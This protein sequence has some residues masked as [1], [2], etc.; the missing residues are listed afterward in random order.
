V[1]PTG[2][3]LTHP[4]GTSDI[5]NADAT[6][7]EYYNTQDSSPYGKNVQFRMSS[8]GNYTLTVAQNNGALPGVFAGKELWCLT[9]TGLGGAGS[10]VT[11][12]A[13]CRD[14]NLDEMPAV[15]ALVYA[16]AGLWADYSTAGNT[17]TLL[18]RVPGGVT[19]NIHKVV[20]KL[21]TEADHSGMTFRLRGPKDY[22]NA[23]SANTADYYD[24]L[25]NADPGNG[26]ATTLA[27]MD[28]WNPGYRTITVK[29]ENT[30]GY[31]TITIA[32]QVYSGNMYFQENEYWQ[33]TLGG[34]PAAKTFSF[35]LLAVDA[36]GN[37]AS[38][39]LIQA[40]YP[41]VAAISRPSN[42]PSE[43]PY[44]IAKGRSFGLEDT[45]IDL[46]SSYGSL[47][48]S[49]TLDGVNLGG[50]PTD[51]S[52]NDLDQTHTLLLKM[53]ET[54]DPQSAP[55]N[56]VST[57]VDCTND[58]RDSVKFRLIPQENL[59]IPRFALL[60]ANYLPPVIDGVVSD[61][62]GGVPDVSWSGATRLEYQD[63]TTS[64]AA[65]QAL[66]CLDASSNPALY[67]SFETRKDPTYD[68]GDFILLG[69]RG[70]GAVTS[71]DMS[72]TP[73]QGDA[74]ILVYPVSSSAGP[75]T[76]DPRRVEYWAYQGSPAKWTRVSE[77][78]SGLT[79]FETKVRIFDF[80]GAK[81]WDVEV[82]IPM[83]DLD[84]ADAVVW[85]DLKDNFLF[86]YDVGMVDT[87]DPTKPLV[88]QYKWPR[89]APD[90][91]GI[92]SPRL[93]QPGE[94]ATAT[95]DPNARGRGVYIA[96]S[97]DFGVVDPNNSAVLTNEIST[98][99]VNS[100][101]A[102]V[103]NSTL[104]EVSTG[105]GTTEIQGEAADGI[106]ATF[107]IAAWGLSY[108]D[109]QWSVIPFTPPSHNPPTG[110]HISE[111][112]DLSGPVGDFETPGTN[113]LRFEAPALPVLNG[114][115]H[116][117]MY[118][119]LEVDAS[120]DARIVNKKNYRNME[121]VD[122]S[123][124]EDKARIPARGLPM[125]RFGQGSQR[126][127]IRVVMDRRDEASA[128]VIMTTAPAS[129]PRSLFQWTAQG[130]RDTGAVLKIGKI[131][132]TVVEPAG[133][134]GYVARHEGDVSYWKYSL[135][136][137]R[138]IGTDHYEVDVPDGGDAFVTPVIEPVEREW[139]IGAS[140]G[141]AFPMFSTASSYSFGPAAVLSVGRRIV[142]NTWLMGLFTYA[143]LTGKSGRADAQW[144]SA[145]LD[146]GYRYAIRPPFVLNGRFGGGCYY[147]VGTG[148]A[149]GGNL[150][151]AA[152]YEVSP[153]LSLEGA[154][155]Y[156]HVFNAAGA[157]VLTAT[158][159]FLVRF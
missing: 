53:T 104:K 140:G 135:G 138:N 62:A 30:A 36:T 20:A 119:D 86:Y 156:H 106:T 24:S 124:F 57:Y 9:M 137:A 159:G 134:F 121:Y 84:A 45:E 88:T 67:L 141:L 102:I 16:N 70:P 60:P 131:A 83:R 82:K 12:A 150:G 44:T 6:S 105:T 43:F 64:D 29:N 149:L 15:H 143:G 14:T 113:D 65:V 18:F 100:F 3:I 98:T 109:P 90:L 151:L 37:S 123:R 55:L 129:K 38:D 27:T 120:S 95:T 58:S 4:D 32:Q 108:N 68:D 49:W 80:D 13:T 122:A 39:N 59:V 23:L 152:E 118:L 77:M 127:I 76:V 97:Q 111:P 63:G 155:I 26:I 56:L 66:R 101:K 144:L 69:F 17:I 48:R 154:A 52:F 92:L 19:A 93:L 94:W 5:L 47:A 116:Q 8:P 71:P 107:R 42:R 89:G 74:A 148:G 28:T 21:R 136:G 51:R 158:A 115:R 125:P 87:T 22:D 54:I 110:V 75:G 103:S 126:F 35:E 31:Y 79:G 78:A 25:D 157:D 81:A 117:C 91:Y 112:Q 114:M 11:A 146:V 139:Q 128:P 96:S 34:L 7:S 99:H 147:L 142:P 1:T 73:Q 46:T 72:V 132:C 41:P 85:P 145:E 61:D 2:F 130:Y 10:S 50:S 133:S 40:A 153:A 33:I